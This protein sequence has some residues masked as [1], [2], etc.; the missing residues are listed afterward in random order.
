MKNTPQFPWENS[1]FVDPFFIVKKFL[2]PIDFRCFWV[3]FVRKRS[4]A[5]ACDVAMV[6]FDFFVPN[7]TCRTFSFFAFTSEKRLGRFV[8]FVPSR[9]ILI[10]VNSANSVNYNWNLTAFW[11]YPPSKHK[12]LPESVPE[13]A[14]C[15]MKRAMTSTTAREDL[16][17]QN[18][19][20]AKNFKNHDSNGGF[21]SLRF[22]AF[23][24]ENKNKYKGSQK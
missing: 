10:L 23:S 20:S 19:I 22:I 18:F 15:C 17:F 3:G 9:F 5:F 7:W 2:I 14:E 1:L 12:L 8:A 4:N 6:S 13:D 21:S 11:F 16:I 24:F